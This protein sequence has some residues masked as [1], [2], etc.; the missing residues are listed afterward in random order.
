VSGQPNSPS[1]P[2]LPI[3]AIVGWGLALAAPVAGWW[4][5]GLPGVVLAFTV[6]AFWVLL[7]FSRAMRAMRAASANPVGQ[8]ANAVMLHSRLRKGLRLVDVL[9]HTRSLGTALHSDPN[10]ADESFMWQDAGSDRVEVDLH[11]GRVTA[12]RLHRHEA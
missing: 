8:V 1:L 12:W 7:Q 9:K 11:N 4:S 5:Y 10:A 2:S 3:S 6:I